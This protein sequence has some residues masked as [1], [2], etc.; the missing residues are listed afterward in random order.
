MPNTVSAIRRV[1]RV[2]K[3]TTVNRLR[4]SKYKAAIKEMQ[5]YIASNKIKEAKKIARE[6]TN[7]SHKIKTYIQDVVS[8]E[9]SKNNKVKEY[10]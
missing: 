3:Q 9:K 7:K 1:R 2:A 10:E 5:G 8:R 4:K 6:S